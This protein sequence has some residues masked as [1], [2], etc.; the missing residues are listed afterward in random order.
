MKL[1]KR[2]GLVFFILFIGIP[3]AHALSDDIKRQAANDLKGECLDL[4]TRTGSIISGKPLGYQY[5]GI[6]KYKLFF[7]ANS[8][9]QQRCFFNQ[10]GA[11]RVLST[12]AKEAFENEM[13]AKC[14][15]D[16]GSTIN[17]TCEL[18]A[19]NKDI[20][21]VPPSDK[22][23][24]A[25]QLLNDGDLVKTADLLKQIEKAGF[26]ELTQ[27]EKGKYEYILAK[28]LSSTNS[29]EAIKHYNKSWAEYGNSLAAAEEASMLIAS[30]K[31]EEHWQPIRKAYKFFIDN[32]TEKEKSL[33]PKAEEN[34]HLTDIFYAA[35]EETKAK[36]LAEMNRL[37]EIEAK[38]LAEEQR[39]ADIEAEKEAKRLAKQQ[40]IDDI[41]AEKEAKRLAAKQR[42]EEI[43][44]EKEAKKLAEQQRIE[45]LKEERKTKEQERKK[46]AEEKR[47]AKEGDGTADDLT[48]KSLGAKPGTT[49]YINCRLKLTEQY[50]QRQFEQQQEQNRRLQAEQERLYQEENRKIQA[51]Q[52]RLYQEENRKLQ[53]ERNRLYQEQI[54][55]Q[56]RQNA[57]IERKRKL[58]A[59]GDFFN[60]L[61]GAS[62]RP[63]APSPTRPSFLRSQWYSNG[64]HM[65]NYDDGTT[66]NVGAG[67]CP[68]VR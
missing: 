38:K 18:Y 33:H 44:A 50:N 43:K 22:L 36:E 59:L 57:E 28:T 34:Y 1:A 60:A 55:I 37:A 27:T 52:E 9:E 15:A 21:Y 32:A 39:L 23:K 20:V 11:L 8:G 35:N 45:Q 12:S 64:N 5:Y 13:L 30:Y 66:L 14:N 40:R 51:E 54:E 56:Q 47:L 62:P 42:L 24:N 68:N 46:L 16:I 19:R 29:N 53:A 61:Q 67:V 49:P 31:I 4:F 3:N 48:C 6:E 7:I 41:N 58:D 26:S 25:E 2:L 65:C 10:I 17:A 63:T